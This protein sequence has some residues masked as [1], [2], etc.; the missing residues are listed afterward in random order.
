MTIPD[1]AKPLDFIEKY[2][3]LLSKITDAPE[4]FQEAAALFLLSTA[5]GRNWVFRSVSDTPIFDVN[6]QFKGKLLNLW[7]IIIGKSRITRKTRVIT[8]IESAVIQALGQ[9]RILS[10]DYTP[11]SLIAAMA[12]KSTSFI[13]GE[14]IVVC[15]WIR[16][17][18]GGFFQQ[19]KKR[20]SYMSTTD[21]LL[22]KIYDGTTYTRETT[23]RGREI[24]PNPYLTCFLASTTH[25]P[26]LFTEGQIE[27]GFLNRFIFIVGKR[28]ERKPLRGNPLDEEEKHIVQEILIFL[29]LLNDRKTISLIEMSSEA[30]QIYDHFEETTED[31]ILKEELGIKEGYC[32]QLPNIVVRLACIYRI[33]RIP[34]KELQ[35]CAV[36]TLFVEKQDVER[37]ITYANKAWEWFAEVIDTMQTTEKV[38]GQKLRDQVKNGIL[39]FLEDGSEKNINQMVGHIQSYIKVAPATIYNAISELIRERRI[40]KVKQGFYRIQKEGPCHDQ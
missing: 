24:I 15:C 28:T 18:I 16:D 1:A 31:R 14:H 19:L 10:E 11:E 7:F 8:N 3:T 37:A 36:Q 33:S 13:T 17:E 34:E 20:E 21:S 30:K 9:N 39:E 29:R 35:D 27:F 5:I 4:E 12:K 38:K 23:G 2:K 40:E 32:A 22:S 26:T 6:S 25:L